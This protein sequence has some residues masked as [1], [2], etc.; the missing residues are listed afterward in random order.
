MLGQGSDNEKL[1][2]AMKVARDIVSQALEARE[3]AGIKVRQPLQRLTVSSGQLSGEL[4]NVIADEVNVKTIVVGAAVELDTNI[5]P[6]LKEE[7]IMRDTM[8][9]VQD[10]RKEAKLH[11]SEHGKVTIQVPE[12]NRSTVEKYLVQIQKDTNTEI[13]LQ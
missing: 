13:S 11:H 7:G 9:L 12:G 3:K 4:L 10:A 8:R 2:A 1:I 6:E 5:T